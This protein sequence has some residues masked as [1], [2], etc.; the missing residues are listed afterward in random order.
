MRKSVSHWPGPEVVAGDL[1]VTGKVRGTNFLATAD[2]DSTTRA[3]G[4]DVDPDL[5][6]NRLGANQMSAGVAGNSALLVQQ[7]SVATPEQLS[8]QGGLAETSLI[9]PAAL[10]AG[11]HHNYTPTS[12]N[13]ARR[14]I[15]QDLSANAVV[16]GLAATS[17]GNKQLIINSSATFTLTL[18][19]QDAGSTA[20]N[21]FL[22][23]NN[24]NYVLA[25]GEAV[26]I[27]YISASSRWRVLG[28]V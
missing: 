27:I 28:T 19:H 14:G 17:N 13:A 22:C 9:T 23:P 18:N 20:A 15:L 21:R 8:N 3:F 11:P 25:P 24:V 7:F 26:E 16:T 6:L 1:T 12:F 2:G 5:G 4:W 10:G